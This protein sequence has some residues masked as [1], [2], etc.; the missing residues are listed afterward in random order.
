M[1]KSVT[2]LFLLCAACSDASAQ[3]DSIHWP[4]NYQPANSSFYVHNQIEINAPA[5]AVWPILIDAQKWPAWY[6]GAKNVVII[7][8][9]LLTDTS[10]FL[11]ETMGL[12]FQSAIKEFVPNK[13]LS[14][15]SEKKSI[16]GYHAWLIIPTPNGCRLITDEA[17]NGWLTFFEK[18]FQPKKLYKLHNVWLAEIKKKAEA[19]Q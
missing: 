5:E 19:A 2:V 18:I 12:K 9:S 14:W 1:L 8:D 10:V 3:T 15:E 16:H 11:W 17:Q 6:V 4:A 7:G 13:R